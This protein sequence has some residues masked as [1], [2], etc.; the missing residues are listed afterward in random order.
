MATPQCRRFV[1]L[2]LVVYAHHPS[3][4]IISLH[5]SLSGEWRSLWT[6]CRPQRC[7]IESPREQSCLAT[8]TAAGS[9]FSFLLKGFELRVDLNPELP[10]KSEILSNGPLCCLVL[11]AAQIADFLRL[12]CCLVNVF[13]FSLQPSDC[14]AATS[15][16]CCLCVS[17]EKAMAEFSFSK[18][19]QYLSQ[20]WLVFIN[21]AF[22]NSSEVFP[23]HSDWPADWALHC[24]LIHPCDECLFHICFS[25]QQLYLVFFASA[26]GQEGFNTVVWSG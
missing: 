2:R 14:L 22:H 21:D 3:S 7:L 5:L 26:V 16:L 24:L 11:S 9:N 8:L 4:I 12:F 17:Q 1:P 18:H 13:I 6:H 23:N 20:S 25:M 10:K 15:L 19:M